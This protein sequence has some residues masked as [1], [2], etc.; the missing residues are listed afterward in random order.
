M[1]WQAL[2]RSAAVARFYKT[3]L[4]DPF[5]LARG[6]LLRLLAEVTGWTP[7]DRDMMLRGEGFLR[8]QVRVYVPELQMQ[9]MVDE[10]E[11]AA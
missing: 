8:L 3:G 9:I 4:C 2:I 1:N 11:K 7:R 6:D 10:W 5:K